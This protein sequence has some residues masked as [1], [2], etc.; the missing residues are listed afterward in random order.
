MATPADIG[1]PAEDAE[2][3]QSEPPSRPPLDL[4]VVE[5]GGDWTQAGAL[6]P[7][8]RAVAGAMVR[9]N[10]VAERLPRAAAA[11]I[12]FSDDQTV[13]ALNT[14]FRAKASATNVLSFPAAPSPSG[15]EGVRSLGDVILACETVYA[16]AAAAGIL[17]GDHVRH[18]VVHGVLHLLGFDHVVDA[19][20]DIMEDLERDILASL[21]VADP[22]ASPPPKI[23]E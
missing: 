15:I 7:L 4:E 18:L 13:R 16:E 21:G 10:A 9:V 20:A 3:L 17:V 11:C 19:D 22:Y 12:A 8:V 6:E 23:S 14:Q 5:D 2:G 1:S